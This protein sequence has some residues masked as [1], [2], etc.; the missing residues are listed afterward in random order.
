MSE[1]IAIA[2]LL[3]GAWAAFR[4]ARAL[5]R[6]AL[7]RSW[8]TAAGTIRSA[9]LKQKLNSEGDPVVRQQLEYAYSVHGHM[10][11]GTRMQFG[12]PNALTWSAPSERLM[13]VGDR[14]DV[15][16]S[17]S[18]PQLSALRTGFSPF[19]FLTLGAGGGLIWL[20]VR[21]LLSLGL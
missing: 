14:I 11:S 7:S 1:A 2:C 19:A 17:P 20:G 21:L 15:C 4:S 13:R 10:Y 8:P 12:I 3:V 16:H 9:R 18:H 6:G 5:M